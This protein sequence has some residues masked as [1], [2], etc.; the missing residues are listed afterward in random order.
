MNNEQREIYLKSMEKMFLRK[1]HQRISPIML[2]TYLKFPVMQDYKKFNDIINTYFTLVTT[3]S[4]NTGAMYKLPLNLGLIGI[5]KSLAPE[6]KVLDYESY[7]KGIIKYKKK[8]LSDGFIAFF[9]WIKSRNRMRMVGK[10]TIGFLPTRY[11][12]EYL[13]K[14]IRQKNTMAN[15]IALVKSK[16]LI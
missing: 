5:V 2:H 12:K 1:Q 13:T 6:K 14:T 16:K 8:D 11:G 4:V 3:A 7:G 9:K 10:S 15:Y